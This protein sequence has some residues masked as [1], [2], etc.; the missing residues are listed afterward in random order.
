MNRPMFST[1]LPLILAS[2]SPRRQQF[3]RNLGIEF[4]VITADI[5][6]IPNHGEPSETFAKRMARAKTMAVARANPDCWVIGAD[7]VVT[8]Q[9]GTILGKP[10]NEDE[11]MIMLNLLNNA[12]HRVMTGMCLCCQDLAI[13]TT[14]IETT[15]VTLMDVPEEALRAYV[16]TGEPLD[17]AGAYGIQG[18][19]SFL[20]RSINGSCTNVIGLPIDRLIA[21]LLTHQIIKSHP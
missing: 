12:T 10:G 15:K 1:C 3:L 11:A 16:Q 9:D 18:L 14:L 20:V 5:E 21:L 6:E 17:K 2:S 8:L 19:G 7:T 13:E 4:T